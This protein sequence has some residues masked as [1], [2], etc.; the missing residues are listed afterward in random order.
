M[1]AHERMKWVAMETKTPKR[2]KRDQETTHYVP[3]NGLVDAHPPE[4]G[5]EAP[6]LIVN[7]GEAPCIRRPTRQKRLDAAASG[8]FHD[9]ASSNH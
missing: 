9:D 1:G 8:R 4:T 6:K 7:A 2:R 3:S 5:P